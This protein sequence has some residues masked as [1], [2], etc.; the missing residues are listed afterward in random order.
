LLVL[1]LLL[2]VSCSTTSSVE[3][4]PSHASPESA[5]LNFFFPIQQRRRGGGGSSSSIKSFGKQAAE[6]HWRATMHLLLR[7]PSAR[8][9]LRRQRLLQQAGPPTGAWLGGLDGLV[10]IPSA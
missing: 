5:H 3:S 1:G 6:Q 8:L 9:A 4:S 7:L 2:P 10:Y